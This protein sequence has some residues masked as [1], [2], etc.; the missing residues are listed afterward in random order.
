MHPAGLDFISVIYDEG[1]QNKRLFFSPYES[2][3]GLP[4][5]F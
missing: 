1:G 3:F 5:T 2:W 4:S